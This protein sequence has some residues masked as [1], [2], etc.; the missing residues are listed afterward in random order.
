MSLYCYQA[1]SLNRV[2]KIFKILMHLRKCG[3]ASLFL[4]FRQFQVSYF[5]PESTAVQNALNEVMVVVKETA[6]NHK[7]DKL[8]QVSQVS[9]QQIT[10]YIG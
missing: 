9:T 1:K 3:S 8:F 2:S 7:L 10:I 6:V 4:F 5:S